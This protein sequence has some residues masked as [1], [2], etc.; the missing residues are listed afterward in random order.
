MRTVHDILS[1]GNPSKSYP[2]CGMEDLYENTLMMKV[3][4]LC[5]ILIVASRARLYQK[6]RSDSCRTSRPQRDRSEDVIPVRTCRLRYDASWALAGVLSTPQTVSANI[7]A[8]V[9]R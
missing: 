7:F 9:P 4:G 5:D 2:N 8:G 6:Q 1:V 3:T